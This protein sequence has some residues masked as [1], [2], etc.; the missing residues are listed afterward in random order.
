[1]ASPG[2]TWRR[3]P[4]RASHRPRALSLKPPPRQPPRRRKRRRHQ[5][6]RQQRPDDRRRSGKRRSRALQ[7]RPCRQSGTADIQMG[8]LQTIGHTQRS[9]NS[10]PR[11]GNR[12]HLQKLCRRAARAQP[13]PRRRRRRCSRCCCRSRRS[14]SLPKHTTRWLRS[15]S[16]SKSVPATSLRLRWLH[17]ARRRA[18][19]RTN[20]R[21][22]R[23]RKPERKRQDSSPRRSR[24]HWTAQ[25]PR[26]PRCRSRSSA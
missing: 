10:C 1:M 15:P 19:A 4:V 23:L 21:R 9:A 20:R 13:S 24:P 16:T 2:S 6:C 12:A 14:G 8:C 3:G 22:A 11:P 7:R 17:L 26:A 5:R 25:R 18:Q